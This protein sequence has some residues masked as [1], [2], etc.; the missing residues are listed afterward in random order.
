MEPPGQEG[1][2]VPQ[3]LPLRLRWVR[4]LELWDI[5]PRLIR[6]ALMPRQRRILCSTF[7]RSESNAHS[8]SSTGGS[9][10]VVQPVSCRSDVYAGVYVRHRPVAQLPSI[11]TSLGACE[12]GPGPK[13]RL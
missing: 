7:C 12:E 4:R 13:P 10:H 3:P 6:A 1:A 9:W 8:P 2:L 11:K 5:L